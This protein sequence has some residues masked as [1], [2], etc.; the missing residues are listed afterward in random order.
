MEKKVLFSAKDISKSFHGTQALKGVNL[1]VREGEVVGLIGENGAG[2]STLLKIIIGVQP[3]SSGEMTCMGSLCPKTPM[4]PTRRGSAWCF[5]GVAYQNLRRQ[6]IIF[7][8]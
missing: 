1:E 8:I 3:P 7:W 2:K 6:N 4:D 5:R